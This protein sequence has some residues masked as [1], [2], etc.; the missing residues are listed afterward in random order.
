MPVIPTTRQKEIFEKLKQYLAKKGYENLG[1]LKP[2]N[3]HTHKFGIRKTDLKRGKICCYVQFISLKARKHPPGSVKV[4]V[5]QNEKNKKKKFTIGNDW[6]GQ[7]TRHV[8]IIPGD[9]GS[10]GEALNLI[11]TI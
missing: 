2:P 6:Y 10:F 7:I 5:R 8:F 11:D 1:P 9:M 4:I 3:N